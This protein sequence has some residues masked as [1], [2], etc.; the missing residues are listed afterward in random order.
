MNALGLFAG[1]GVE[2]EY[3]IVAADSLDVLPIADKLMYGVSGRYE[4][5]ER[6]DLAWSNELVA[7]VI[8]LKTN[9]PAARLDGLGPAFV[10]RSRVCERTPGGVRRAAHAHG[11]A[12]VDEPADRN[13]H[14]AA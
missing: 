13:A 11:D 12:S 9:G 1:F 3:M 10:P 5:V 2:L 6:G 14:L 8:E 7:H 4:D